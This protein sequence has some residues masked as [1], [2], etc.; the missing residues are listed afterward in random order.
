MYWQ[1]YI[2]PY[3]I[4]PTITTNMNYHVVAITNNYVLQNITT[5]V[6]F[7]ILI[8]FDIIWNVRNSCYTIWQLFASLIFGGLFGVLWGYLIESTNSTNLQYFPGVNNKEVCSAPSK[9]TF[10]CNV[11]KGD[12]LLQSFAA[13]PN[14]KQDK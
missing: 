12:K 6:F 3:R 9:S 10:R 5:I 11:Y 1:I 4:V 2:M 7:S 14:K 13:D 8:L